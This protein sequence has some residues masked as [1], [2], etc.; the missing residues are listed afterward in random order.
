MSLSKASIITA[1]FN[2]THRKDASDMNDF[3]TDSLTCQSGQPV[4]IDWALHKAQVDDLAN[5]YDYVNPDKA[6]RLR[7]CSNTLVVREYHD[8]SREVVGAMTCKVRLCPLCSWRRSLKVYR[9]T[10]RIMERLD[11]SQK[12]GYIFLTLTMRNCRPSELNAELNRIFA[13][14]N[15][16][17]QYK[18]F[19]QAVKGWYRGLEVT[20]DTEQIITPERYYAAEKVYKSRCIHIGDV[21]PNYD[22]YHPHIHAVLVVN[23]SYFTSRDYISA[24]EFVGLWRKACGFDYDPI[25]DIRKVKGSMQKA[26]AEI[27]KYS[28]K[29]V[30]YII[31]DDMPLSVSSVETLDVALGGRR[32]AAYGGIMRQ[33]FR[34]LKLEDSETGELVQP[35]RDAT[36]EEY[37]LVNYYWHNGYSRYL[38]ESDL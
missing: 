29:S 8:G 1:S 17:N 28:A 23:K 13:G 32:L 6:K 10:M 24:A 11:A 37:K 7:L 26:V 20:H 2:P 25:V 15:K 3:T 9:N 33:I 5:I 16:L 4:L 36:P 31:P 12:Y 18:A 27:S 38:R 21:N 34:E 14:W 35:E 19:K 22:T 30:D